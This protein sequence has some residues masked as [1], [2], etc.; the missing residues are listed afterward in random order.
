MTTTS[1]ASG[2][3]GDFN[4][5]ANWTAGVPGAGDTALITAK[6]AYSVSSSASNSL[7]IL[8]MAKDAR[9]ALLSL[10]IDVT[11]GTGTGALA[12]R[13]D[14]Q[15][16]A[17]LVLGAT[18][19][20]TTFNNTGVIDLNS[21]ADPTK[22]RIVGNVTLSGKGTIGLEGDNAAVVAAGSAAL[23]TNDNTITG[24]GQI[25]GMLLSV[26][27][28]AKGVIDAVSTDNRLVI[29]AN[30]FTNS[31]LM[32]SSGTGALIIQT[33]ITQNG[34][35]NI[36]DAGVVQIDGNSIT[37]GAISIAKDAFLE[38]TS[39]ESEINTSKA[40]KNAGQI[41]TLSG[42]IVIDGAVKNASTG[43][44]VAFGGASITVKGAVTKGQANI[45][46]A[47]MTF[48][49]PS[50]AEVAFGAGADMLVLDDATKFTGT[51]TGMGA[52]PD[53]AIDLENITFADGF[54]FGYDS[55][56]SLLTVT[57]ALTGATD[58]I[59]ITGGGTFTPTAAA[60]GSTL[61]SD[62][63][64]SPASM[65]NNGAQLLAQAMAS[66]GT[67]SGSVAASGSGNLADHHHASDFLAP[68]AVHGHR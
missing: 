59:K 10:D 57:D 25:G 51:V 50:S 42:D 26:V 27:N 5:A 39:G 38:G 8:E 32:E 64:P 63:P 43:I 60:D 36:K 24:N 30:Q 7:G 9:L 15:D 53:A 54:T 66:F 2:V 35:G 65:P 45:D 46:A 16:A 37:G 52:N 17:A 48:G 55:A 56:K 34:K 21:G 4:T 41:S 67:A 11:V 58:K 6:G 18:G 12:G 13:I 29:A 40:I 3:D 14:V 33:D 23:L 47:T 1:W 31:G 28:G 22:L 62:P 20:N 19:T 68:G 61:F 49:G 44:L